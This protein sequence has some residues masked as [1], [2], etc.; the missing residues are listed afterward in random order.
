MNLH[1]AI[2]QMTLDKKRRNRY[3]S[4]SS[5]KLVFFKNV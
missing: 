3:G 2:R 5:F 1:S 4:G